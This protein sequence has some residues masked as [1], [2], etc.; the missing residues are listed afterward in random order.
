M[1]K[2][3]YPSKSNSARRCSASDGKSGNV[4]AGQG[5]G[6]ENTV[7]IFASSEVGPVTLIYHD[8]ESESI[9]EDSCPVDDHASD[10]VFSRVTA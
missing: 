2:G 1:W 7:T 8:L 10:H 5:L 9:L 6:H 4:A 3:C